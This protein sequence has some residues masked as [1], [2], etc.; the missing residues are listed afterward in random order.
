M[1]RIILP[2]GPVRELPVKV[3]CSEDDGQWEVKVFQLIERGLTPA[4]LSSDKPD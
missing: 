1:K 3:A 2:V 4:A